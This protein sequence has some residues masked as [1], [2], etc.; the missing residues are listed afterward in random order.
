[1]YR[2]AQR[3]TA[4]AVGLDKLVVVI[5]DDKHLRDVIDY[6][7][8]QERIRFVSAAD[9][10]SGLAA[11]REHRPKVLVVDLYLPHF[12]GFEIISE[13]RGDSRFQGMFIIAITGMAEDATDLRGMKQQADVIV[14]K[15]IDDRR[16]LDLV[17][18]ALA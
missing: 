3:G 7:F 5:E 4:A 2:K 1:M 8:R 16:L 9:G 15:P 10:M 17:H 6:L 12:S 18:A 14:P 11:V 13:I